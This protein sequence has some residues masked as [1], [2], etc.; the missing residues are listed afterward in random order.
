MEPTELLNE[1]LGERWVFLEFLELLRV[2]EKRHDTLGV[3]IDPVRKA[4]RTDEED[5][6][7][8]TRLIMVTIVALPATSI[9][10]EI[11][12]TSACARWPGLSCRK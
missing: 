4:A 7:E 3:T 6:V 10:K 12:T 11:C 5:E 2:L 1:E 8:R 9:K